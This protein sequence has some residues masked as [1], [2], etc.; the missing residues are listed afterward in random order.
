MIL[1]QI[2]SFGQS[3]KEISIDDIFSISLPE[4]VESQENSD[5]VEITTEDSIAKITVERKYLP[6][7]IYDSLTIYAYSDGVVAGMN[8]WTTRTVIRDSYQVTNNIAMRELDIRS[9]TGPIFTNIYFFNAGYIYIV[10][11]S[12]KV[13]HFDHGYVDKIINSI[14]KK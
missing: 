2:Q 3:L 6:N 10:Q 11:L 14:E 4:N 7:S 8:T 1:F 13:D 9:A 12:F 5:R